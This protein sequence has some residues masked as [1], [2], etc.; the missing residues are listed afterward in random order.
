MLRR[1]AA[2]TLVVLLAAGACS[3]TSSPAPSPAATSAPPPTAGPA[4]GAPSAG[5]SGRPAG[6]IYAEIR[7]QV[8]AIRG[9][10]PTAAVEPVTI[11]AAQLAKNLEAEFDA[12]YSGQDLQDA[13]DELIALGLL[14]PGTSLRAITLAF[15][16]G[17]VAGYY[18]PEQDELFVVSRS[19]A[20]GPVD[21]STYAH[22]FTH[23][24]QDQHVDLDAL[25]IEVPDQG[26]RS[27]ARLALVEG[28]ATSVQTTWMTRHLTPAELGEVLAA[29][30][31]PAA[32]EAFNQAPPYL[33]ETA[34]LPYQ[35]GLAFVMDLLGTGGY[36]AV[37][38]AFADPPDSTEQVLH[39]D[40]YR[41]REAPVAVTVS[42][43][44]VA[45]LGDGWTEVAQDTLGEALL[46]I[47]LKV[48][49]VSSVQATSAAAG[50]GGDRLALYRGPNG[51]LAAY[52][53]TTWDTPEDADAFASAARIAVASLPLGG[54]VVHAPE[55]P[56]VEVAIGAVRRLIAS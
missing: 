24:L 32:L 17:Q 40:K 49:G 14:P 50:W 5:A 22:E 54:A 1:F 42:P 23:Q 55:A 47:W 3:S 25:G 6:D 38:A 10:Q 20:I 26:D 31:D 35:D 27:L 46:R 12:T 21:A 45:G 53:R 15:Q 29:G 19:G 41:V 11:D 30:L 43:G 28:D 7:T 18:S 56:F 48:A 16:A 13:E 44:I 2:F 33:R 4:T 36:A 39:P 52:L 8:E 9:L 37:D 51:A 34:L